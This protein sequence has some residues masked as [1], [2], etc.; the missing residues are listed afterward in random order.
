MY[1]KKSVYDGVE[2]ILKEQIPLVA[3]LFLKLFNSYVSTQK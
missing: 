1:S 3:T 2:I